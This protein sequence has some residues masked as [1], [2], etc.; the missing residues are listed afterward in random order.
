MFLATAV[1]VVEWLSVVCFSQFMSVEFGLLCLPLLR[2]PLLRGRSVASSIGPETFFCLF[3]YGHSA[4]GS[5]LV[6]GFGLNVTHYDLIELCRKK[7]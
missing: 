6:V 4:C 3:V 7:S 5:V 1:A 2:Y